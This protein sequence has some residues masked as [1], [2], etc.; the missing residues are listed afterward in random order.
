[1]IT[2]GPE[3][4]GQQRDHYAVHRW[5]GAAL[6]A[7]AP[8]CPVYHPLP[9]D[10]RVA[11]DRVGVGAALDVRPWRGA[12]AAGPAACGVRYDPDD[13]PRPWNGREWYT[14]GDPSAPCRD[15]LFASQRAG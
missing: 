12:G 1:V 6:R 8:G 3:G 5:T 9:P 10:G 13:V 4:A 11:A 15:D 14:G 2:F 7:T